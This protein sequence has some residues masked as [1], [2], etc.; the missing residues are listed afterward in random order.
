MPNA[1]A[2]TAEEDAWLCK[3]YTNISEDGATA[4]DQ[5]S[6]LLWERVHGAY[7]TLAEEAY[8]ARNAGALQS[9]WSGLI[10][11]DVS[12]FAS[13]YSA[14]K[15]EE[16]SG[17]TE[18]DYTEEAKHRFAAKREQLNANAL[19][20]YQALVTKSGNDKRA[21][22]RM[23]SED[24]RLLHCYDILK[25]SVRFMRALSSPR[26]RQHRS[27]ESQEDQLNDDGDGDVDSSDTLLQEGDDDSSIHFSAAASERDEV[28]V[29]KNALGKKKAKQQDLEAA[30]D[31]SLAHSQSE[32][33]AATTAQVAVMK[34]QLK[35]AKEKLRL[36][37]EQNEMTVMTASSAYLTPLGAEYLE[38]RQQLMLNEFKRKIEQESSS[39][40]TD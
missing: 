34:E 37:Q 29:R 36:L 1:T 3:A 6:K 32:L 19:R 16:H 40:T 5:S 11:P 22:P 26:K 38:L 17:W 10:R 18:A 28:F 27:L 7:Q 25:S 20:A 2:W 35:V 33:A 21:K 4:T 12:L 39:S 9:R 15:A 14:V 30:V 8:P 24:F 23:K 31:R 13:L